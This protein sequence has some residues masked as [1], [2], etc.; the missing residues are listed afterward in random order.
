[1]QRGAWRT[2]RQQ[3]LELF[4][5]L[6]AAVH[7]TARSVQIDQVFAIRHKPIERRLR[8]ARASEQL[9]CPREGT[10]QRLANLRSRDPLTLEADGFVQAREERIKHRLAVGLSAQIAAQKL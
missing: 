1:M 2:F 4:R 10:T 8:Q 6:E 7:H 3:R 5:G 9:V